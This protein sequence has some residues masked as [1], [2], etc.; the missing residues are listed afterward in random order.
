MTL[1]KKERIWICVEIFFE[2]NRKLKQINFLDFIFVFTLILSW[3]SEFQ[4]FRWKECCA[5]KGNIWP[6]VLKGS[7][8]QN[9]N[10][11]NKSSDSIQWIMIWDRRRKTWFG[12]EDY[13]HHSILRCV[14]IQW[15]V[16]MKH[17]YE[18]YTDCI[19]CL[20]IKSPCKYLI[21]D[22]FELIYFFFFHRI[23]N[24]RSLVNIR[25]K[26]YSVANDS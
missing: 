9:S 14:R 7:K 19:V 13:E 20:L 12:S 8:Y 15:R 6:W 17:A 4:R 18:I 10:G 22:H 3:V 24:N 5:H 2:S 16:C 1:K 23:H 25:L 21:T 11:Y 26:Y